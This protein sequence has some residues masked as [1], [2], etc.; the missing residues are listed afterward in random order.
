MIAK[1]KKMNNKGMT[2]V[3]ILIAFVL[4]VIVTVSMYSMV[5]SFKEKQQLESYKEKIFTYKNL[6]TKEINDDLIKGGLVSAEVEP[7]TANSERYEVT[8]KLRN[9][10]NKCLIVDRVRA[11]DYLYDMKAGDAADK[12]DNFMI[13]YGDC[14]KE[15][16]YPIPDL[17]ESY[18]KQNKVV[19]D[20]RI[21]DVS[22][23]T[24][25]SVLNI[26]IGFY[27]PELGNRYCIDILCPINF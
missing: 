11:Y 2:V 14:D 12:D 20:L 7:Y 26:Y 10:E 23:T 1:L 5:S 24:D 22:I 25:N 8:M 17:G 19:K 16:E 9:G 27:H 6:L 3:E 15:T 21:D 13:S 4:A 18:N